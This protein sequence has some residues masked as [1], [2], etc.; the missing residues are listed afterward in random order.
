MAII[1][2]TPYI[3][4][5]YTAPTSRT[6]YRIADKTSQRRR[7][8]GRPT[9][10]PTA[11]LSLSFCICN[12]SQSIVICE[13]PG[14][15][16]INATT[17]VTPTNAV[18]TSAQITTDYMSPTTTLPTSPKLATTKT[19]E[20][21]TN[22]VTTKVTGNMPTPGG[23]SEEESSDE[24]SSDFQIPFDMQCHALPTTRYL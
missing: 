21:M 9:L 15:I 10:D 16:I 4:G 23:S 5:Q 12:E 3:L 7:R 20:V 1:T 22:K 17:P 11:P 24:E 6:C 18:T 19:P 13:C 14:P 2:G 8:A